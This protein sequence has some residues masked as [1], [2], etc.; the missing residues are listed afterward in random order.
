MRQWA[1]S[2]TDI[3]TSWCTWERCFFFLLSLFLLLSPL[4]VSSLSSFIFSF[5]SLCLCLS[6]SLSLCVCLRVMFRVMFRVACDV[7]CA[8]CVVWCGAL[9]NRRVSLQSASVCRSNTSPCMPA[10]RAH[11]FQHVRVVPVHTETPHTSL[12][13]PRTQPTHNT[14]NTR[15][16]EAKRKEDEGRKWEE[17]RESIRNPRSLRSLACTPHSSGAPAGSLSR[18]LAPPKQTNE[19]SARSLALLPCRS[20]CQLWLG[21]VIYS[22]G[23]H[24]HSCCVL[25]VTLV[26]LFPS[27]IMSDH[28]PDDSSVF[29][30]L[31]LS[32]ACY[33]HSLKFILIVTITCST[34]HDDFSD[35]HTT[36]LV[37]CAC[38]KFLVIGS[39]SLFVGTRCTW[40]AVWKV[41]LVCESRISQ[42]TG[43]TTWTTMDQFSSV[44]PR[45]KLI[46]NQLIMRILKS[47]L[48]VSA[49]GMFS[50]M[51]SNDINLITTVF[52]LLLR[53]TFF[54]SRRLCS[55]R[56]TVSILWLRTR[57]SFWNATLREKQETAGWS[58]VWA[59]KS[60]SVVKFRSGMYSK[61]MWNKQIHNYRT[62]FESRISA[63]WTGKLPYSE[64]CRISSWS[65]DMEGHA[66]KCVE[67]CCELANRTTEQL[68]K[69]STLC[70]DD[71][72]YK[73]EELKSCGDLSK[74]CSQFVRK[75]SY[76]TRIGRPDIQWSVKKLARSITK[77]TKARDKRLSRLISFIHYTSEYKQYCHLGYT[78]RRCNAD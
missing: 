2:D 77:W 19:P 38:R 28:Y 39:A 68:H 10:T 29:L 72:H 32:S 15:H 71:H 52:S 59:D 54:A 41:S 45:S 24:V 4:V 33:W 14:D 64:N 11:V 57:L 18:S 65:N 74:V 5:F 31:T 6:L 53:V 75:C 62:I 42:W 48:T 27:R 36:C 25:E 21:R 1:K 69:V 56:L 22:S 8:V 49:M 66:K 13:R 12:P 58:I 7:W 3:F 73:E 35:K 46:E 78:E 34:N 51:E 44:L 50:L 26:E 9:K 60:K 17:G 67:R 20:R 37:C 61:T 70:I 63:E 47:V 16:T 76:L 23:E 43:V 40:K 55:G 30:F